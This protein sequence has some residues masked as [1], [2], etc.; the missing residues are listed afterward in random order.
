MLE[1]SNGAAEGKIHPVL[2]RGRASC[3]HRL[4]IANPSSNE[5][6]EVNKQIP[7]I[8]GTW[9]T[10]LTSIWSVGW[11]FQDLEREIVFDFN[12]IWYL[13]KEGVTFFEMQDMDNYGDA[14]QQQQD[15]T[16]SISWWE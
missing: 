5:Y 10:T 8:W 7:Q 2:I 13:L 4:S 15:M 11:S 16:A 1:N 9:Q 12:E 3:P 14:G 6:L